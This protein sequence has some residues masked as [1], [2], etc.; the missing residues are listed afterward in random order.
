MQRILIALAIA[1]FCLTDSS[2]LLAQGKLSGYLQTQSSFFVRDS[3]IKAFNT[4]QYDDQ[5][6]STE[7]WIDL[8]YLTDNG[9]HFRG[10]YDMFLNSNLFDPLGSQTAQ[11]LGVWSVQKKIDK[12]DI[13]AGYIYDQIGTGAAFQAYEARL[14]GIDNALIGLRMKYDLTENIFV[15]GF[16][17]RQKN[18]LEEPY[19]SVIKGINAEAFYYFDSTGLSLAPGIGI[20]N[21]TIDDETMQTIAANIASYA[22]VTDIFVPKYNNYAFSAYNTLSYKSLSLYTEGVYKTKE[23]VDLPTAE[24]IDE[25]GRKIFLNRDGTFFYAS[26]GYA[27]KGLGLNIQAKRAENFQLRTS[28]LQKLTRGLLNFVPPMAR[29]NTYRLATRYNA[30]TQELGEFGFQGDAT[31]RVNNYLT[32]SAN[33]SYI[34]NLDGEALYRETYVDGTIKDKNKKWKLITGLQ[35]Q[36]Y[37]QVIY[38]EKRDI[39]YTYVETVMPFVDFLYTFN[40]KAAL[41][42]ELQY[43]NTDQDFG[44]WAYGLMEF[45]YTSKWSITVSNMMTLSP[46]KYNHKVWSDQQIIDNNIDITKPLHFFTAEVV[47]NHKANRFSFGRIRQ[48]EGIVCTGGICRYEPAF[49]GYRLTVRSRL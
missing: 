1:L 45:T 38:E 48:V 3:S 11:G 13:T 5:F 40:K 15:K 28:P 49:N 7:T 32:L 8:T 30:A 37:N 46:E 29:Q 39:S 42:T 27:K 41:R 20:V 21:R 17:G 6:Y 2:M 23:A 31:Y 18:R 34:D 43:M 25:T 14:L 26:L 16:V 47:F 12:L 24:A 4:R 10:R 36:K 33:F 19:G 44:S 22:S 9:F 35:M